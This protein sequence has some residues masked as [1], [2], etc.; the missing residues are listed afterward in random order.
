MARRTALLFILLIFIHSCSSK[1]ATQSS[2]SAAAAAASQAPMAS[3]APGP[4]PITEGAVPNRVFG[5]K[6]IQ[7]TYTAAGN[8]NFYD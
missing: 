5:P 3:M 4:S 2:S 6:A 8:L 7:I 1:S